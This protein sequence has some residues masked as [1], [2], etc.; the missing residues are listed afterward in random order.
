M[1][2]NMLLTQKG[3][4]SMRMATVWKV[5]RWTTV[6]FHVCG[7]AIS[8]FVMSTGSSCRANFRS[9]AVLHLNMHL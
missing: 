6:E 4:A 2:L 5:Y 3:P 7:S 1:T 8:S 9:P